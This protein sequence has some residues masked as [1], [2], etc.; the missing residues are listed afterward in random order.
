MATNCS[1][2]ILTKT[3]L[4]DKAASVAVANDGQEIILVDD[5]ALLSYK[6]LEGLCRL[7]NRPRGTTGELSNPAVAVSEM[8]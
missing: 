6:Y 4:T 5:F 3:K 8:A 1:R 7:L 2:V